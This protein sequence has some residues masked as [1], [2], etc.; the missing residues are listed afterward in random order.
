MN[1]YTPVLQKCNT[2]TPGKNQYLFFGALQN[3]MH[4][5]VCILPTVLPGR[6][7]NHDGMPECHPLHIN[8]VWVCRC[9]EPSHNCSLTPD[10]TCTGAQFKVWPTR[11]TW[12]TLRDIVR[13]SRWVCFEYAYTVLFVCRRVQRCCCGGWFGLR[14]NVCT[15]RA[16][17]DTPDTRWAWSIQY[18]KIYTF[19]RWYTMFACRRNR[20]PISGSLIG[21]WIFAISTVGH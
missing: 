2:C 13:P 17:S 18:I 11:L 9:E 19:I 20:F 8:I 4:T 10:C 1:I 5:G 16:P 12:L 7:R 21:N 6:P 15:Q 3:D 14:I